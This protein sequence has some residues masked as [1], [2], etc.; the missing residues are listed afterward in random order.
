MSLDFLA[1]N[2]KDFQQIEKIVD[3]SVGKTEKRIKQETG[4]LRVDLAKKIDGAVETLAIITKRGFD[5]VSKDLTEIKQNQALH[6]F[7]MSEMVSKPEFFILKERVSRLEAK[8]R[9]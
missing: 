9:G 2:K 8:S 5:G 6:D 7:K 4:T 1:L 3:K